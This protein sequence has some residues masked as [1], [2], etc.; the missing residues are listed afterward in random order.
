MVF[1]AG[2][3]TGGVGTS[4]LPKFG[5][6]LPVE[7]KAEEVE[8]LLPTMSRIVPGH[9]EPRTSHQLANADGDTLTL[10]RPPNDST[11]SE[12]ARVIV[13]LRPESQTPWQVFTD[14]SNDSFSLIAVGKRDV[15]RLK[16]P[17]G[18]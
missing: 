3:R 16:N 15:E 17:T 8:A 14:A 2:L 7:G 5:F 12:A 6:I 13:A 4:P 1:F 9:W 10:R 18:L 11:L